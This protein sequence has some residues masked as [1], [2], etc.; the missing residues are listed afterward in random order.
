MVTSLIGGSLFLVFTGSFAFAAPAIGKMYLGG[1]QSVINIAVVS[2]F[3]RPA[4]SL[5]YP[6]GLIG[7]LGSI[8]LGIAIWRSGSLLKWAGVLF[9]IHT[10]LLA[11]AAA[12][13]YPLELAGGLSL[14]ISGIWLALGMWQP[15]AKK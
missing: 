7:T 12:F 14:L 2:F 6:S 13:S 9:A 8:I 4:T 5:L 10:P 15:P 3:S 11:F 1:D